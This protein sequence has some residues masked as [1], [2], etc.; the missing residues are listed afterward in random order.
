MSF[1]DK[2][3][4]VVSSISGAF[5]ITEDA[6]KKVIKETTQYFNAD[7]NVSKESKEGIA[8][9]KAYGD[10]ETPSL[11]EALNSAVAAYEIIEKARSEK[12]EKLQENFI[13]PLNDLILNLKALNTKLKEAEAA[14]KDLEKA[15]KQLEKVQAKSEEKLKPGELDNAEDAV[16]EADSK[17]KK[18]ETEAKTATDAFGKAKVEI[19]KQILQKLVE[20]EK[21]FHEKSLSAFVSL[22]EKVVE[23]RKEKPAEVKKENPAEVKKPKTGKPIK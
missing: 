1:K 11:K 3:K 16:K 8:S 9:L 2:L 22:K 5:G 23:V 13:K 17:A 14:K 20:N 12:V 18:E 21:T 4:G 10:L 7:L 15:Q 19:L 6:I